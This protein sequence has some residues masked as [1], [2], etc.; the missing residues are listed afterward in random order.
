[1]KSRVVMTK[2]VLIILKKTA[3]NKNQIKTLF[4]C[5]NKSMNLSMCRKNGYRASS[6]AIIAV[7]YPIF[8][9]KMK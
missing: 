3:Y 7:E 9:K 2:K 6:N 8:F 1:M 4:R 5:N